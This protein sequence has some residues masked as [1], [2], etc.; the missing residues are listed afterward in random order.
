MQSFRKEY[1]YGDIDALAKLVDEYG[2][3]LVC[4]MLVAY[5]YASHMKKVM[6]LI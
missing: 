1:F 6:K 2:S 5:G 3:K 4:N